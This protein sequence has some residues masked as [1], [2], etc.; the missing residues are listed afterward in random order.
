MAISYKPLWHLL[1]EKE[2]KK[3]DL[4]K[5]AGITSNVIARMGKNTYI[6]LESLEKICFALDCRIEDVVE[7]IKNN[8]N[9]EK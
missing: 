3:D 8:E 7:V 5:A 6:N 2:M 4:K 9:I 1:I